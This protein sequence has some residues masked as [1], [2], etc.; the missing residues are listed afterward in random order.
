MVT[1]QPIFKRPSISGNIVEQILA[2][3]RS[4]EI[5]PGDALPTEHEMSATFNVGRNSVREA[6][7]TLEATGLIQISKKK[8]VVCSLS[9]GH[10]PISGLKITAARIHEVFELRKI[11]EGEFAA[12][13]AERA[14]E[15][16]VERIRA[17]VGAA[18]KMEYVIAA[19]I[20][21]HLAVADAAHNPVLSELYQNLAPTLFQVHQTHS[22]W[23]DRSQMLDFGKEAGSVH[24]GILEAIVSRDGSAAKKR[25][26]EHLELMEKRLG[27]L[28]NEEIVRSKL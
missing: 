4:G 15:N 6:M 27:S 10:L 23:K 22:L 28:L 26:K 8:R 24:L 3:I 21:F 20:S 14:Q 19:D 11:L 5:R 7:K 25:M 17:T 1:F 18:D 12:L 13:A 9:N 16:D 2:S